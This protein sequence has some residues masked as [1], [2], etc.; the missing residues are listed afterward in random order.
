M[1]SGSIHDI[2]KEKCHRMNVCA[3]PPNAHTN[4]YVETQPTMQWYIRE[5]ESLGGK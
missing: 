1:D 5:V 4:S 3:L 2:K